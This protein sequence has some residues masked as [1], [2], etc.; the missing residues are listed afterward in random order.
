MKKKLN[1]TIVIIFQLAVAY[2]QQY[3]YPLPDYS[4]D[5]ANLA[6]RE[7]FRDRKFGL[8]IHW[9]LYSILG[10]GEW[11]MFNRKIPHQSYKQ[12][13]GLFDPRRFN[14]KEWVEMAKS[15]G[16]K[17]ITITSRHHDGFSMFETAAS[18]YNI[19]KATSF[20]RDPLIELAVEAE[21]EGIGL[22]FYYS[23]LDWGRQDYGFGQK[24]INGAPEN[25]DWESYISFMKKQLTELIT[26]YP[27]VK[28]IWFDGHWERPDVNWHYN[29]LYSLI[30]QLNPAIL[31]GN[32]HHRATLA[33][34][35]YQLFEK[36]LPGENKTG[37][38]KGSPIADLP[39]E[40]C[41]TMNN[42]WGFNINDRNFKTSKQIIQML[43]NAA[44][45]NGNLLLNVGPMPDGTV[46]AEFKDT[47]AIVG[48]WLKKFGEAVYGT[49]GNVVL[50]QAWGVVTAKNKILFAHLLNQPPQPYIF[51]PELKQKI[52]SVTFFGEKTP[53]RYK[54]QPEG[55]FVYLANIKLND[56]DTILQINLE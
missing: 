45:R 53:L 28:A 8:F 18:D 32:N 15:A 19:V 36:D 13:A 41:E 1:L 17:Y 56:I 24:I 9:G 31:I 48:A 22:H 33:G 10:D 42:S 3:R 55:V 30:H 37:Y 26:K 4:P 38:R 35:D 34:E 43:V 54:Q 12:L 29:E 27:N 20:K 2:S 23:L 21:K 7:S 46:Q 5:Q 51:L 16:V 52:K 44:G 47:L 14:A 6:A 40:T 25:R 39:L 49:R 11:V 50:P